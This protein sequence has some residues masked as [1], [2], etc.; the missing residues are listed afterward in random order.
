MQVHRRQWACR[1]CDELFETEDAMI[2]HSTTQHGE[3][4]TDHQLAVLLDMSE[5]PTDETKSA[6]CPICLY[7]DFLNRVMEHLA[8]HME[9]LALFALPKY[10]PGNDDDPEHNSLLSNAVRRLNSLDSRAGDLSS[11][12]VTVGDN[13]SQLQV[14]TNR[15]YSGL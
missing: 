4:W 14:D 12:A 1:E 15:S 5:V 7:E 9:D 8:R 2:G 10:V 13:Y 6:I 3:K 11:A